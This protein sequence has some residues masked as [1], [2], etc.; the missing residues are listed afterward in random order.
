EIAGG[1]S[2]IHSYWVFTIQTDERAR[3]VE[4]LRAR[5]F[6]ATAVATLSVLPP[7][8]GRESLE[9][10]ESRQILARMIYLPVYPEL[11]RRKLAEIAE[12]VRGNAR[13]AP[14][15]PIDPSDAGDD[16]HVTRMA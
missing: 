15:D 8:A 16:V 10:R 11:P 13:P 2:A 3:C 9:A 4:S 12:I 7:P 5:G 14:I 6:D 1:D